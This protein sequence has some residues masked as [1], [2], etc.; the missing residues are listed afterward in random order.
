MKKNNS[1]LADNEIALGDFIKSLWRDKILILSIIIICGSLGYFYALS[2]PQI[3]EKVIKINTIPE[4]LLEPYFLPVENQYKN[5]NNKVNINFILQFKFNFLSSQNIEFFFEQ[6]S[7]F[8]NFKA[9]LKLRNIPIKQYFSDPK[10]GQRE[11]S[12]R[13]IENEYFLKH[14]KEL[15][16]DI[17][18][19]EYAEFTKKKTV[20]DL[21]Y[22]LK[23]SIINQINNHQ[24][25]LEI[26]K[27]IQLENP[28][29]K[30]I[31]QSQVITEPEA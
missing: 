6:S 5:I 4:Q 11:K 12:N 1:Y 24:E 3:I 20:A 2:K 22:L 16:G 19:N 17:F 9:H 23:L 30:T 21:K 13:I 26:A 15:D 14:G 7:E 10:F 31:N 25:A 18:M 8:D 29:L 27:K 28:I